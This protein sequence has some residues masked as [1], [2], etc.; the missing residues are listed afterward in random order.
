M[1]RRKKFLIA[2]LAFSGVT[3]WRKVVQPVTRGLG[4]Y[5]EDDE[6]PNVQPQLLDYWRGHG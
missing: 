2:L 1:S 3:L 5:V 4:S 6:G